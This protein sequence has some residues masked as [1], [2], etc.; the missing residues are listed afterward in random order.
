LSSNK[1]FMGFPPSYSRTTLI[2]ASILNSVV[3][4]FVRGFKLLLA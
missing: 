1:A 3:F 4:H 2:I